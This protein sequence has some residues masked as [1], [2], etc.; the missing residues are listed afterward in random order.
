MARDER[1]HVRFPEPNK[2]KCL[3]VGK[4]GERGGQ[5]ERLGT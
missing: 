4:E 3:V 5:R 1:E 2:W